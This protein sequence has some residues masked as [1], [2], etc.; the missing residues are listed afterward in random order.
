[1]K[2]DVKIFERK[3]RCICSKFWKNIKVVLWKIKI[4]K[5]YLCSRSQEDVDLVRASVD[6]D[7]KTIW[8]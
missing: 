7:P 3:L 8:N 1:M 2:M 5:I 6:D 4:R